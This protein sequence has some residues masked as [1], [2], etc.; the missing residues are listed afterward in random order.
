MRVCTSS[1]GT[2]LFWVPFPET[3]S[4]GSSI[5]IDLESPVSRLPTICLARSQRKTDK[6]QLIAQLKVSANQMRETPLPPLRPRSHFPRA[7]HPFLFQ[8]CRIS[9]Q[10]GRRASIFLP[11]H[12]TGDDDRHQDWRSD[13]ARG[14]LELWWIPDGAPVSRYWVH[15]YVCY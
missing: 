10:S 1:T 6:G 3:R 15:A 13:E 2:R 11:P 8:P 4:T 7:L 5:S 9:L 14:K 12:G